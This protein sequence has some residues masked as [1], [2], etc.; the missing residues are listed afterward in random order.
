MKLRTLNLLKWPR[1]GP[2]KII[3]VAHREGGAVVHKALSKAAAI[4][5]IKDQVG[6]GVRC[7]IY[8]VNYKFKG[9]VKLV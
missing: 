3:V 2:E 7:D 6:V 9:A 4:R 1:L 8:E 5:W